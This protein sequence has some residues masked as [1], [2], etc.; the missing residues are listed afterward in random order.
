[1]KP[2]EGIKVIDLAQFAAAPVVGRIM[3]EWGAEVIKV[4]TAKGDGNRKNGAICK[5]PILGDDEN[6]AFDACSMYKKYISV[7]LKTAEG[8]SILDKLLQDADVL[9]LNFREDS[10]KRIG[11][12]WETIHTKY[13][14]IVYVRSTGFGDQGPMK[15]V[16]GFD[17]T[18]YY[19]RGAVSTSMMQ[20]GDS[21][22]TCVPSFGDFTQA[23]GLAAGALAAIIGRE[24]TG[25]G[26][27]VIGNLYGTALFGL[28]WALQGVEGGLKY[29]ASRKKPTTPT[30]NSFPTKDGKWIQLCGPTHDW[31]YARLMRLIGR[32]D[33]VEDERYST[34]AA[35][36]ENGL[37]FELNDIIE[38]AFLQKA[39]AEWVAIFEKDD[40]PCQTLFDLED[41]L[42]DEQAWAC[43]AL[44]KVKYPSGN[45]HVMVSLPMR[46]DSVGLPEFE[47]HTAQRIG[48]HTKEVL[49]G[50][51]FSEEEI[52]QWAKNGVVII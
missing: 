21:P 3:G 25:L 31:Y 43:G 52:D 13:P 7:D 27:R 32:E 5:V 2:L 17:M 46:L 1:M 16:G 6:P 33:L 39:A 11:M 47:G 29:P 35:L 23:L 28:T 26:D 45:E 20:E 42:N 8:R 48:Y 14:R 51:G 37:T 40:Y 19:S 44:R 12:D 50:H 41:V 49:T 22:V 38:E 4:E 24:K 18:A 10:A 9:I 34:S 30:A 15:D 36:K